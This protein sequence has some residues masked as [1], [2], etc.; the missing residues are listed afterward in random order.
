VNGESDLELELRSESAAVK[1]LIENKVDAPL[2]P[3]Q[4]SRY[5]DRAAAYVRQGRCTA[6]WTVLVAPTAYF[7]DSEDCLGFDC[8]VTYEAILAWFEQASTLGARQLCKVVLLREALEHGRWTMVPDKAATEFWRLYWERASTIA[9]DLRMPEPKDRP[10][11]SS[12]IFFR[13]FGLAPGVSLL[14]KLPYGNVDLQFARMGDRLV[15]ITQRYGGHLDSDMRVD[16]ATR[17]GVVRIT[18]PRIDMGAPF[19]TSK[20]AVEAGIRAATRLLALY[21]RVV[22]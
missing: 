5:H 20:A 19:V 13:P 3:F 17:S 10:A 15:E 9:P 18:V 22:P 14:H 8:R 16:Q 1:V 12:F 4:A 11:T 6:A 7:G 2:Q 21:K